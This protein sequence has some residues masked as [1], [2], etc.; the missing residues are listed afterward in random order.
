MKKVTIIGGG[1]GIFANLSGLKE[2]PLD[3]GVVM[4]MMDS[5]GSTGKLRVQLGVLPPGD[6]RQCLVALSDAPK[7]WRDLFLYRFDEGDFKG[8]NFGNIFLS[9][10]EKLAND[11]DE[12][13]E[14]ATYI[15]KSK[16][17]VCPVTYTQTNLEA[18][19]LDGTKL[20][21]ED[22]IDSY[23][24]KS[25]VAELTLTNPA[26]ATKKTLSRLEK[27]DFVILGPG[28]LFTSIIPVLLVGGVVEAIKNSNA[29][30][31][32]V[33][34]L[35]N[36]NGQ[37][38]DFTTLS[39]LEE[40]HK[41]LDGKKIDVVLMSNSNI[42]KKVLNYY[43]DH[44]ELPIRDDLNDKNFKGKIVKADISSTISYI[45]PSGDSLE[46]TLLRHDP[47]KVAGAL[48]QIISQK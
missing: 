40:F 24:G 17:E 12:V 2:Y 19:Y 8:H 23:K 11:Y 44:G 38:T 1:T 34:N 30:I 32:L 5:G 14:L 20:I 10:L 7:L 43:A 4:T 48:Y 3:L 15:L 36:K 13:V 25:S 16:G 46:R 39:L 45:K 35:M 29:K 28:D 27:S 22:A 31:V 47:S 6:L 9:T 37:T 42:D 26:F 33:M 18:T 41:Y 21:G